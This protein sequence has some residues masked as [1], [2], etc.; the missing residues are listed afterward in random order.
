MGRKHQLTRRETLAGMGIAG[1]AWYTSTS[2]AEAAADEKGRPGGVSVDVWSAISDKVQQ[3][4][5]VDTHEH[6]MEE[7]GRLKPSQSPWIQ[8]DDWSVLVA[9]YLYS[10]LI[11]AGLR[12]KAD[13]PPPQQPLFSPDID[14]L[15]KWKMIKP[16]WKSVRDTGYG[17]VLRETI[18]T[19]YGVEDLS[20]GTIG[21]VQTE[22]LK[23]RRPGFYRRLLCDV[24]NIESCQVNSFEG[25]FVESADPT[26]LMQDINAIPLLAT[27]PFGDLAKAWSREACQEPT[28]ITARCLADWH[29]VIDWWFD[30]YGKYAVAVKSQLAYTRDIDHEPT[31]PE[32]AEGPFK[33]L[34]EGED[35][36]DEEKKH[37]EDHLFWYTVTKAGEHQL[38]IK[39]HTGYYAG[40]NSM[41]LSRLIK[42]PGSACELCRAAPD[43]PFVFMHICYP[44]YEELITVA[45]QYANAHIDMCWAWIVN[46]LA[47]KDFLK[48]YLVTAPANK[49]LTFGA[50]YGMVENVV[51][52]AIIARRGIAQALVELVDEGWMELDRALELVPQLM[53]GNAREIFNLKKKTRTLANAPWR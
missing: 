35:L 21:K 24:A 53:H 47:S 52:H 23:T 49:V 28:D 33:K 6:L 30:R 37:L 51:G 4:S 5:L 46:P 50:D 42:N 34:V 11:S 1:A 16:Y 19:L 20:D 31:P 17:M 2:S 12:V 27:K 41:P 26:L 15:T 25:T 8:C 10:D 45:K 29:R 39:L 36:T 44:Y 9:G 38:P 14:P 22:Y 32:Q 40:E 13:V 18:R 43:T 3:S 7:A 48:K